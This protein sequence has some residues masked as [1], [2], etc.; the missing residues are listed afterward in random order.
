MNFFKQISLEAGNMLRSKFLLIMAI[1]VMASSVA[2]P[3]INAVSDNEDDG[4]YDGGVVYYEKALATVNTAPAYAPDIDIGY[5]VDS[6][7]DGEPL[8]INGYTIPT[9]NIFYWNLLSLM[10]EK[11]NIAARTEMTLAVAELYGQILDAEMLSFSC[12]SESRFQ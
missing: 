12:M 1:L 4:I 6:Y 8:V 7:K 5:P 3:I 10:Q 11:D 9:E 2:V